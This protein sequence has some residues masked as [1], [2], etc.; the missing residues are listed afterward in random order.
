MQPTSCYTGLL[1]AALLV[2]SC[3]ASG[4]SLESEQAFFEPLPV[5][6]TVSRM[7]KP[8]RETPAAI[9][10]LDRD[11]IRAT[12]Y[13][14]IGRLLR[15]VPGMQIAQETGNDQWVSYHGPGTD[16]PRQ[17]QLLLDGRPLYAPYFGGAFAGGIP[18]AIEDIERIEVVRGTDSA[19]YGSQA[20]DGIVNIITRHTSEETGSAVMLRGGTNGIAGGSA[21]AVGQQGPLGLRLT[22]QRER[23]DGMGGL[24]DDRTTNRANLRG[25]LRISTYD[26]ITMAAGVMHSD[27]ERGYDNT[28]FNSNPK[29]KAAMHSEFVQLRWRHAPTSDEEFVLSTNYARE[30]ARDEWKISS[31]GLQGLGVPLVEVPVN[32][33]NAT[34]RHNLEFEHHFTASDRL[35]L[36]WGAEWRRDE[37]VSPFLLYND[38]KQSQDTSRLY[39]NSEWH[40]ANEW[41][42]NAGLMAENAQYDQT[43]L[44]PRVFLNWLP[45]TAQSWRIG[46]T[47]AYRQ[48]GIFD[49][50]ADVRIYVPGTTLLLQQRQIAN[51]DIEPPRIDAF[52][53][54]FLGQLPDGRAQ[55]DVR[56][57][58]EETR[59][60]IRRQAVDVPATNPFQAIVQHFLPPSQW[61]NRDDAIRVEGIEYQL[62]VRPW[63]GGQLL[64]SHTVIRAQSD[65]E[66]IRRSVA[67]YTASLTWLQRSGPWQSTLTLLRSGPVDA[68]NGFTPSYRYSVPAYTTAD[69]SIA[70]HFVLDGG[71]RVEVRLTGINLLGKHQELANYPLQRLAGD[72]PVN[73]VE[74]QVAL[75]V[76]TEF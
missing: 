76:T 32:E 61:V 58:H 34:T 23:D 63:E 55:I 53:L 59:D 46:Y 9:T 11:L 57:F 38:P 54:G 51:P 48:P 8:Q 21:R 52:E 19:A 31:R 40:F 60:Q 16:Y 74:P 49:R 25:D 33:N 43:R 68:G 5:V 3:P 14:D 70:R 36:G 13:R 62:Q 28:Q 12:G 30:K 22:V 75:S 71:Q 67:P 66:A 2:L 20:F 41:L 73:R 18:I 10:I 65:E 6:L 44:S 50:N 35:R 7:P 47:R 39:G 29:R 1:P 56:L 64:F 15:L 45:D 26:E 69:A 42:L 4:Q 24:H 72:R 27:R 17:V 37:F